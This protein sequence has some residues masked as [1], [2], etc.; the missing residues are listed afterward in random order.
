VPDFVDKKLNASI[1]RLEVEGTA[2]EPR[3]MRGSPIAGRSS[4]GC[5]AH[6]ILP[7]SATEGQVE[8]GSRN[9]STAT[10]GLHL[11][12]FGQPAWAYSKN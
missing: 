4:V 9:A 1:P 10:R 6:E 8:D 12:S 5:Y 11:E 2:G 7:A 3:L